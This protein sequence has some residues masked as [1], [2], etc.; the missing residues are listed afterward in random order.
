TDSRYRLPNP[1]ENL[2]SLLHLYS[3]SCFSSRPQYRNIAEEYPATLTATSVPSLTAS[4][5]HPLRR[6]HDPCHGCRGRCSFAWDSCTPGPGPSSYII[7]SPRRSI[8]AKDP[9]RLTYQSRIEN[10]SHCLHCV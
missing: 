2:L 7:Y 5:L 3:F 6:I 8:P 9:C 10:L 4:S 1:R